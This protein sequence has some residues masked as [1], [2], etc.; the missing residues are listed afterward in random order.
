MGDAPLWSTAKGSELFNLE[1]LPALR[2]PRFTELAPAV[3]DNR[4]LRPGADTPFAWNPASTDRNETSAD[5]SNRPV[6][7]CIVPSFGN[8]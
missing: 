7:P 4:L 5:R 1:K 2:A 8:I 6:H 3:A